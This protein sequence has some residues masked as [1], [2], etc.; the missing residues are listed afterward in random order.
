MKKPKLDP[1]GVLRK[2]LQR[3]REDIERLQRQVE[4]EV[5]RLTR[6]LAD[7]RAEV[8]R[9]TG[10]RD[11]LAVTVSELE[12]EN[13][14]L[15]AIA[16]EQKRCPGCGRNLPTFC[17]IGCG[18]QDCPMPQYLRDAACALDRPRSRSTYEL[19]TPR[20]AEAGRVAEQALKKTE[21]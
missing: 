1:E 11:G 13:E 2:Q 5:T 21:N 15:R 17:Q 8:E 9:V 6:D 4:A 19:G 10:Y 7:A 12:A 16:D 20:A 3:E 18:A 14:R